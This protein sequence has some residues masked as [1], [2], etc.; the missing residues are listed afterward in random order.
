MTVESTLG[1]YRAS[2]PRYLTDRCSIA[3]PGAGMVWNPVTKQDEPSA[4]ASVAT[5]IP[6]RFKIADTADRVV[7]VGGELV[8]LRTYTVDLSYDDAPAVALDQLVVATSSMNQHLLGRRFRIDDIADGSWS[9][10]RRLT[11]QEVL[12]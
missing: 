10:S 1:R 6:C 11:V 7:E 2:M 5:D 4:D 9:G 12:G 3:V 8:T